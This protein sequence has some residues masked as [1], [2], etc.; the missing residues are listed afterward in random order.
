MSRNLCFLTI[1]I[2]SEKPFSLSP[3]PPLKP[4]TAKLQALFVTQAMINPMTSIAISRIKREFQEIMTSQEIAECKIRLKLDG[5]SFTDL[6]GEIGGPP[7]GVYESGLFRVRITIPDN[8]P[9][10]PP[11]VTFLTKIW[12]PNISSVT[13]AVC[14][15][16]L[17]D[18]WAAAL[19]LRTVMLSIQA[20]LSSPE[21]DDP[22]DAV[23]AHQFKFN[24]EAFDN[25]AVFWTARYAGGRFTVPSYTSKLRRMT[26]MGFNEES[27]VIALSEKDWDIARSVEKVSGLR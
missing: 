2:K 4:K 22:Q 6:R 13:G 23:V 17:K 20:L 7:D 27:C 8:Y 19:T 26:E 25:T 24:R 10:A 14:L 15:D 12:H 21:P 16:I 5:D 9:F 18:Q 1:P 11:V 3:P